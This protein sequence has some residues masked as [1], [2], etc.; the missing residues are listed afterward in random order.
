MAFE[1]ITVDPD[2]MGGVPCIRG[3]RVTVST[4]LGQLAAGLSVD[5]LLKDY[6]Y[7]ERDDVRASLEYAAALA[8]EREV[9]LARPA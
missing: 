4:V 9:A 1:R 8:Q 7:L 3:L 6:P 2:Q 5:Q